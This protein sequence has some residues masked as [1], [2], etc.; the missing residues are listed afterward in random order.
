MLIPGTLPAAPVIDKVAVALNVATISLDKKITDIFHF[1]NW[2]VMEGI[3]CLVGIR[4]EGEDEDGP[5]VLTLGGSKYYETADKEIYDAFIDKYD[6]LEKI[7]KTYYKKEEHPKW[8]F[9]NWAL[10]DEKRCQITWLRDAQKNGFLNKLPAKVVAERER[11]NLHRIIAA[12]TETILD[13]NS[14]D[15]TKPHL[16]NQSALIDFLTERYTGYE[17]FSKSTLDT[18]IASGKKLLK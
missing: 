8:F 17:G 18:V 15:D 14:N 13:E 12:L 9:I 11:N 16:K 5:Y 4:D 7:W 3:S 1:G 2:T 6:A 10:R